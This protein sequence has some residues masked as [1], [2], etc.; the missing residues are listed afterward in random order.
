MKL[1]LPPKAR[2]ILYIITALGTPI[3]A[4][5][6]VK[7]YIGKDEVLLWSAEIT[8]VSSMAAFNVTSDN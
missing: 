3:M 4:Y 5:L 1:N 8:V 7:G 2:V 6:L